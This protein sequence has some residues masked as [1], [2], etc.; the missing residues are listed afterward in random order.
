MPFPNS[1]KTWWLFFILSVTVGSFIFWLIGNLIFK[2]SES[3]YYLQFIIASVPSAYLM[4]GL[5]RNL[6]LKISATIIMVSIL[7]FSIFLLRSFYLIGIPSEGDISK[8][9]EHLY[10]AANNPMFHEREPAIMLHGQMLA[11]GE[12]KFGEPEA[13]IQYFMLRSDPVKPTCT[14]GHFTQNASPKSIVKIATCEER[15]VYYNEVSKRITP[16]L[17]E[18]R[19]FEGNFFSKHV[20]NRA[21]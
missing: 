20:G 7:S 14:P 4:L 8:M 11:F 16:K 2:R 3:F 13:E 12:L 9:E 19:E 10:E 6:V 18:Y 17:K 21:L 15:F 5:K 1:R